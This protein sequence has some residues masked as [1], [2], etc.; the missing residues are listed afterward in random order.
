[1][2]SILCVY[3]GSRDKYDHYIERLEEK[4]AILQE[5][6]REYGQIM[7]IHQSIDQQ[8]RKNKK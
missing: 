3:L 4:I 7:N 1:M 8:L 2:A 5:E 6:A